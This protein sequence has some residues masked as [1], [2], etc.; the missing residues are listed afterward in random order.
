MTKKTYDNILPYSIEIKVHYLE[1]E[2]NFIIKLDE[3]EMKKEFNAKIK[4]L[5]SLR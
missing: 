4:E 5:K 2:D 3:E 1:D